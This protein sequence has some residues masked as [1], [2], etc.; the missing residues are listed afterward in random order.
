VDVGEEVVKQGD[1][2]AIAA[3]SPIVMV[4]FLTISISGC[5]PAQPT[6]EEHVFFVDHRRLARWR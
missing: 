6:G 2:G 1:E 3:S 4:S 5:L